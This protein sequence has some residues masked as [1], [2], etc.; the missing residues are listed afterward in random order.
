MRCVFSGWVFRG[1][2]RGFWVLSKFSS[3]MNEYRAASIAR[4]SDSRGSRNCRTRSGIS[5]HD[6]LIPSWFSFKI[7]EIQRL[8]HHRMKIVSKLISK[9]T[10]IYPPKILLTPQVNNMTPSG[11]NCVPKVTLSPVL[12]KR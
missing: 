11:K 8:F 4:R 7:I 6:T 12:G 1:F 5:I 10:S 3:S 2:E 9:N